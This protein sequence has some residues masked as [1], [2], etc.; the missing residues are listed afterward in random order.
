M[1][2]VHVGAPCEAE[3]CRTRDFL[4]VRCAL[5]GR[6][7]CAAHQPMAAHSCT[8]TGAVAAG[9]TAPTVA[10]LCAAPGCEAPVAVHG[11]VCG[12]CGKLT[13]VAHRHPDA[14]PCAVA[15]AGDRSRP[16]GVPGLAAA[17]LKGGAAA[18]MSC[19]SAPTDS[20]GTAAGGSA[21]D[22][23]AGG[24]SRRSDAAV[25][26]ERKV[27]MSR[28]K[29]KAPLPRG[30]PIDA[31]V[32]LE[33][34]VDPS[35]GALSTPGPSA[36]TGVPLCFDGRVTTVSQ[37]VDALAAACGCRNSNAD[38]PPS[39]PLRLWLQRDD[40]AL[41]MDARL[42]ALV[43]GGDLAS[44]DRVTLVRRGGVPVAGGSGGWR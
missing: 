43:S 39:S 10:A 15:G 17:M 25:A 5:C 19:E 30:V 42:A 33:G 31:A 28:L 27:R 32:W 36:T 13:C 1:E 24:V 22:A 11:V 2:F 20:T 44:G 37:V 9:V 14:H 7:L 26:M 6:V 40:A 41:P 38:A 21:A 34:A 3:G 8:A 4:P 29:V 12:A 23:G 18:A 35:C 16:I